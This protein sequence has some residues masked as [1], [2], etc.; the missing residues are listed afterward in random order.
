MSPTKR[1]HPLSS[2][3]V[4]GQKG[5]DLELTPFDPNYDDLFTD[6]D[7]DEGVINAD[8]ANGDESEGF[9][10]DSDEDSDEGVSEELRRDFVD[11]DRV[12]PTEKTEELSKTET[13]QRKK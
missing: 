10:S 1:P 2:S 4:I 5:M 11:E 9:Y 8:S 6:D 3:K 12:V 13:P 7:E